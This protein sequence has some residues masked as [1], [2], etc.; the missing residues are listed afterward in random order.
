MGYSYWES[1]ERNSQSNVINSLHIALQKPNCASND[2]ETV[3]NNGGF[4]FVHFQ[5]NVLRLVNERNEILSIS[6]PAV[7]DLDGNYSCIPPNFVIFFFTFVLFFLFSLT[8]KILKVSNSSFEQYASAIFELSPLKNS[9]EY[10]ISTELMHSCSSAI[11][12]MQTLY[13]KTELIIRN[14]KFHLLSFEMN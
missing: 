8:K 3:I 9:H 5:D 14:R 13:R 2:L 7:L 1:F 11:S 10:E 12:I 4:R 6:F